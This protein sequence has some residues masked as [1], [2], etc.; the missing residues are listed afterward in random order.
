M[1][2][3]PLVQRIAGA[4]DLRSL[5]EAVGLAGECILVKPNWFSLHPGNYT[6]AEVLDLV[7]AALPGRAIVVESYTGMRHDG[8]RK[9]TPKNGRSHWDWLRQQDAWFLA[10]TGIGDVLARHGAEFVNVTEAVWS[11]RGAPEAEVAT[12]V[13]ACYGAIDQPELYRYVPQ[14]LFDLAGCPLLSLARYKP[15]WSLSLQNLFGLIPDPLRDRWHGIRDRDLGRSIVNIAT[16][17]HALFRTVGLVETLAPFPVYH[18]GGQYHTP[19]G[20]YDLRPAAGVVICG[21][22]LPAVDA[23]AA[24]AFG[25]DP[26]QLEYLQLAEGRLGNWREGLGAAMPPELAELR[27]LSEGDE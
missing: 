8:G 2:G 26:A 5:F 10:T 27:G 6:G 11:G 20:D 1:S 25:A 17:Y 19:W 13:E 18:P 4:A 3:V 12:R 24:R 22:S 21:T 15:T 23:A 7:L 14:R 9:I 16:I